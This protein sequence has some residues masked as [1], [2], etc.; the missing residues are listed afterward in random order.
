M[1]EPSS[2]SEDEWPPLQIQSWAIPFLESPLRW[3]IA[4][5]GRGSG[6][7][8]MLT[9]IIMYLA[10]QKPQRVL[11]ARETLESLEES[12]MALIKELIATYKGFAEFY[13][14]TKGEVFGRNGSKFFFRGLSATHGTAGRV[15]GIQGINLVMLEEAQTISQESYDNLMPTIREKGSKLFA[16]LNPRYDGDPV[17]KEAR[18]GDSGVRT[19]M[20]NY[21]GQPILDGGAGTRAAAVPGGHAGAVPP[22]VRRR[23]GHGGHGSL[24]DI[25]LRIGAGL[26]RCVAAVVCRGAGPYRL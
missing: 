8:Y 1:T 9:A 14:T 2:R 10:S 23:P 3:N 19:A 26:S 7:S 11:F 17:W 16:A 4:E 21:I 25:E 24:A 18:S 6:K 15:R 13:T 12:S 5:G 20:V 22:R